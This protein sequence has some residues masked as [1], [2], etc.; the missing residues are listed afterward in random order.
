M[1]LPRVVGLVL[2]L[3]SIA[4]VAVWFRAERARVGHEIHELSHEEV[5]VIRAIDEAKATI[6]RLRAP[7]R[8]RERAR[9]MRLSAVPPES[10]RD[11]ESGDRLARKNTKRSRRRW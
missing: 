1:T 9:Q 4:T 5:K 7:K 10:R 8:I 3:A 2:V 11:A 6:A